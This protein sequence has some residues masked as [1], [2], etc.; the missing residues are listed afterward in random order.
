MPGKEGDKDTMRSQDKISPTYPLT[1]EEATEIAIEAYLYAS[2]IVQM[3]VH[4][5]VLTNQEAS[6]GKQMRGPMNQFTHLRDFPDASVREVVGPNFDTIYSWLWYDVSDEPLVISLPESTGHYYLMP[7]LDAWTDVFASPGTRTTGPGAFTFALVGPD[8]RGALPEGVE[9]I[10]SPTSFGWLPGRTRASRKTISEANAFQ[11]QL[12][13]VPLSRWGQ[14]YTPPAGPVDLDIVMDIP[15]AQQVRAMD[16]TTFWN[17]FG[18]LWQA[19]PPH[20][21]DYPILH[22][23]ARLGL[24]TSQPIDFDALPSQSREALTRAVQL[25]Q[26]RIDDYWA[27]PARIR[28]GW[29]FDL[30]PLGY[31]GSFYLM[32]ATT[33]WWAIGVNI[34]EDALYPLGMIDE[35]GQP[36]DG[37]NNYVLHFAEGELP[38]VDGFWSLSMYDSQMFQVA[39]PIDRFAIGDR[40]E[41]AFN[42]DGSLSLYI[43]HESPGK[44]KESNWLP[45][46]R[47]GGIIPIMRLYGP[48]QDA[49]VGRWDPPP[50]QRV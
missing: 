50:F 32:R 39:N 40:D 31:W 6:D 38:P 17:L 42:E 1:D 46:L 37:A 13:A 3:E 18:E 26:Q 33:A 22:R 29:W 25:G 28:N 41:L 15:P 16:A 14:P 23:M 34:P 2:A 44:D 43:Q 45:S 24:E 11:D 7:I 35:T 12:Q 47:S 4:R 9:K 10:Q 27:N 21:F 30:Q 5:R 20:N 19:N 36:L 49:I 48:Q 8:W